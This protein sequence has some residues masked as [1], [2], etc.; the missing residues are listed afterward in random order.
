MVKYYAEN[1]MKGE[2]FDEEHEDDCTPIHAHRVKMLMW[3]KRA[4][5]IR[6]TALFHKP[7][8]RAAERFGVSVSSLSNQCESLGI[9]YEG[10]RWHGFRKWRATMLVLQ[11]EFGLSR[12]DLSNVYGK[13][14]STLREHINGNLRPYQDEETSVSEGVVSDD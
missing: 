1:R 3:Q 10:L 14:R 5:I 4:R 13:N 7:R 6:Q 11:E 8:A 9:D 2:G 12:R